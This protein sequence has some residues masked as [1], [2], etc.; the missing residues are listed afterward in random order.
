MQSSDIPRG[1]WSVFLR[2]FTE[3]HREGL[4][5]VRVVEAA[6]GDESEARQLPFQII[7]FIDD[8]HGRDCITVRAGRP[9]DTSLMQT[10]MEPARLRLRRTRDGAHDALAVESRKG[11]V[12][13]LR[14]GTGRKT[15]NGGR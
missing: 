3:R 10:V 8:I 15:V 5:N 7:Q 9:G 2:G 13:L 6:T 12:M 4:V 1:E 14:F 11:T